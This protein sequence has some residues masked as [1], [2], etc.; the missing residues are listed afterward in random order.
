MLVVKSKKIKWAVHIA[1]MERNT[2]GVLLG[3]TEGKP[4]SYKPR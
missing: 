4:V 1:R 3:K 2:Y